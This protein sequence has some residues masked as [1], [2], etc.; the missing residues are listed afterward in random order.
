M[1]NTANESHNEINR[2]ILLIDDER[3]VH[4]A[5]HTVLAG[6][7]VGDADFDDLEAEMFGDAAEPAAAGGGEIAFELTSAHQG[8]EGVELCK[9]AVEADNPFAMAFVDMRMPP[10]IDGLETVR[11]LWEVAP[12]LQVVICSAYTDYSWDEVRAKLGYSSRLLIL[13]KPFE[14]VEVHQMAAALT[15]KW[16][17]ARAAMQQMDHLEEAVTERT[18]DL[19]QAQKQLLQAEKMA[20]VGQLA[21]GVAHEINNPIGY[22]ASNL[23]TLG[24]YVADLT[25]VL[26]AF[27]SLQ[28]ALESGAADA[29]SK[30]EAASAVAK[31]VDLPFLLEDLESI[32]S[33]STEGTDRVRKIV[34][35]L[36]DFSHADT[37]DIKEE[38]L[39]LLITKT[40]SVAQNEV[41][42]KADLVTELADLPPVACFGGKLSQVILNLVVNAAQ[43]IAEHG[44]ITVRTGIQGADAWIEVQDNGS[45]MPPEVMSKIFDP[46]FTTKDVGKGTGL[47][48]NL[49]YNIIESH[50]GSIDVES[51]VGKG[52]TFRI[53]VP[54][55]GPPMAKE[56]AHDQAA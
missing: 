49:A 35:D 6:S 23:N 46:F 29:V 48:L 31:E 17:L 25:R 3:P 44:V 22:I 39:N 21:A 24:D 34:A 20:S 43:A 53:E 42:Y 47:G 37:P 26:E 18:R 11:R 52:T 1:K 36:R 45:G 55:A 10:G 51:E 2:R 32:V 8:E 12:E 15:E 56:V 14:N 30:R 5:Y 7:K 40:L 41:K 50:G 38:D 16:S 4:D 28:D 33:E 27:S 54:I 9:Q 19:E 13:K